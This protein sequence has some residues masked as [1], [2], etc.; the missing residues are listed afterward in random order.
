MKAT[1]L[2]ISFVTLLIG[3][4][5]QNYLI[6]PGVQDEYIM[7]EY[8]YETHTEHIEGVE[9]FVNINP[10]GNYWFDENTKTL[11]ILPEPNFHLSKDDPFNLILGIKRGITGDIAA[12]ERGKIIPIKEFPYE[13]PGYSDETFGDSKPVTVV[14]ADNSGT[15]FLKYDDKNIEIKLNS[16]MKIQGEPRIEEKLGAKIRFTDV[17]IF[18]N[19]GFCSKANISLQSAVGD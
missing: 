4:V 16:E 7:L 18:K 19:H 2:C 5:E 10:A 6:H 1:L 3:C 15:V 11:E 17:Y 9:S 13:F 12:S 14:N 8:I